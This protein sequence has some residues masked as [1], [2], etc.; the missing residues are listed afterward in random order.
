MVFF[1]GIDTSCDETSAAV[2]SAKR[3]ILSNVVSSQ[4]D[5]HARYG[6]VVPELASRAHVER[7]AP[8]T[9]EALR[10]AGLRLR[11]LGGLAVTAGPGLVGA[12]LV[13]LNFAKG[14]AVRNALLL[15][16]VHHIRAHV[17]S[18][19]LA[20]GDSIPLP[21]LSLVV[22]G[23]HTSL[24]MIEESKKRHTYRK[25]GATL[26]DAAGEA[27]DKAAKLM[28][29]G[30]PGGPVIEALARGGDPKAVTLPPH[31]NIHS[32]GRVNY[33]FSFSGLKS[34]LARFVRNR[35]IPPAASPEEA[36]G[37]EDLRG[38]AASFQEAAFSALI[39]TTRRAAKRL[40]PASLCVSGGVSVNAR[41]AERFFALG[42]ELGLP[43]FFPPKE[44]TTDNGAM[45]AW[46]GILDQKKPLTHTETLAL[47]AHA[48]WE[49]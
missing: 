44:L 8:V 17:E 4:A 43:V 26:D 5:M 45:V 31:P 24:H 40:R 37:R 47:N 23:G 25:I 20:H 14:L 48:G 10:R 29:L 6:G 27:F 28:G 13:G 42:A 49:F 34:A 39:W 32:R 35:G 33:D 30:Y 16:A 3:E 21:A 36:F 1:L 22:S 15:V 18:V 46:C 7:I 38:I 41:L 19:F 11:D 9:E 2:V 12:L